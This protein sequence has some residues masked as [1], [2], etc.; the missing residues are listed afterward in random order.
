MQMVSF[1]IAMS[2]Y[3]QIFLVL[4]HFHRAPRPNRRHRC[5]SAP[6]REESRRQK[7]MSVIGNPTKKMEKSKSLKKNTLWD[8]LVVADFVALKSRSELDS[9][10]SVWGLLIYPYSF[11]IA[12]VMGNVMTWWL[13]VIT[14]LG[15][16]L[17]QTIPGKKTMAQHWKALKRPTKGRWFHHPMIEFMPSTGACQSPTWYPAW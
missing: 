13:R 10:L 5:S 9:S 1:S 2:V 6:T 14:T 15:I 3:R 8:L 16:P 7:T 17:F 11:Q 12:T 4:R